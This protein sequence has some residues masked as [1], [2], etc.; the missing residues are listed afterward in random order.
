MNN[1]YPTHTKIGSDHQTGYTFWEPNP[2][3]SNFFR[4]YFKKRH[5]KESYIKMQAVINDAGGRLIFH[6]NYEDE[7]F[8]FPQ[9]VEFDT[10]EQLLI[11][12]LKWS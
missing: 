7:R 1:I 5:K 12:L 2:A 3:W 11:W 4:F 10:E 6:E 8:F 9:H